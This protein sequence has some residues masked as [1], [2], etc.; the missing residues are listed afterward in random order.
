M[1]TFVDLSGMVLTFVI[2]VG[3]VLV[4]WSAREVP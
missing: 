3:M 1:D 4:W 2:V